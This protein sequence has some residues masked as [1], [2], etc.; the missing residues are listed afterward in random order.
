MPEKNEEQKK[1]FA[2][3]TPN[4]AAT[5]SASSLPTGK[6]HHQSEKKHHTD[7]DVIKRK[8]VAAAGRPKEDFAELVP[9]NTVRRARDATFEKEAKQAAAAS[10]VARCPPQSKTEEKVK[11]SNK[12][13]G[14][15]MK[16]LPDGKLP[17][18]QT[19]D[20]EAASAQTT[21]LSVP[22]PRPPIRVVTPGAVAVDGIGGPSSRGDIDD[23]TYYIGDEYGGATVVSEEQ[24]PLD[25]HVVEQ[26]GYSDHPEILERIHDLEERNE[27][28][29][30]VEAVV[31]DTDKTFLQ[32]R[33]TKVGMAFLAVIVIVAV[34]VG[35]V[36]ATRDSGSLPLGSNETLSPAPTL[37]PSASPSLEPTTTEFTVLY[38]FIASSSL[39]GGQALEDPSSPQ[40]QAL[41]WLFNNANL[42][43]YADAQ[44]IQRYTLAV[45]YYSSNGDSWLQ[46]T[47]WLSDEP[48]CNWFHKGI[49][50]TLCNAVSSG[51]SYMNMGQNNLQGK[52]P[53]ELYFLSDSLSE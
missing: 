17:A 7:D 2:R 23:D 37:M 11:H 16:S 9:P 49:A 1:S 30:I 14:T 48:E 28:V 15:T 6:K 53:A 52:L 35:V 36:M 4:G 8:A 20:D 27:D 22:V 13:G 51:V 45:L 10:G 47:N 40:Y 3:F 18:R 34:V 5:A 25:A 43:E 38:N 26:G 21:T 24:G 41:K 39:D 46:S 32:K 29:D 50:G 31:A 44:R 12:K 19:T 42:D 33:S